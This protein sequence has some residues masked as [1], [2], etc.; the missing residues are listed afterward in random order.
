MLYGWSDDWSKDEAIVYVTIAQAMCGIAK[1]L[2]KL[3]GKTV[4]KLVTPEEKQE[5]LFKLVSALTGYKN[6]LKGVGYF[7]G[8]A[9]LDWSYFAAIS[10]NIG[11][12]IVALPF[13]IFGLT[14]QLGRVA[15]KNITLETVFKQSG[16]VATS[17]LRACFCLAVV[18]SG[19]RC[20]CLSICD[21]RRDWAG[22]GRLSVRFSRVIS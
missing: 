5:R 10:V 9:L 14:T 22:H 21:R 20:L 1:D 15:S 13:A 7:M 8:A 18:T 3:G 4:T 19:L 11:F 12:I 2:T 17:A 6:S 16:N